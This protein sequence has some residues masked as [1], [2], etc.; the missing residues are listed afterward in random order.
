MAGLGG[1]GGGSEERASGFGS[2]GEAEMVAHPLLIA[3]CPL[4]I[5]ED[6]AGAGPPHR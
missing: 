1:V 3:E 5:A 2:A 6:L 4:P